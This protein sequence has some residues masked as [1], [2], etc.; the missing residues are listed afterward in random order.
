MKNNIKK[1]R[2]WEMLKQG[3]KSFFTKNIAIKVLSLM[4]AILLWGY[5]LMTQNPPRVKTV[6]D[7]TVSI[8]GEAD[9]TTRKLTLR[10]DRAAL[11]E[12]VSVRVRTELTSYADISADDITASINL[13]R[14]TSTGKHTVRIH[15]KS[16][17]GDVVSV[18]P[19][20]IEVEIDT[21]TTRNI[22]IEI[23]EEGELPEGYWAGD[24]QLDSATVLL[25]GPGTDLAKI[26]K[27][28][29]TIDLTNRTESLNQS[30]M[31]ALYDKEGNVV[32]SS[33]LFGGMPTVVAKQE[34]LPS[35]LVP[36]DVDGA[37]IGREELPENFEIASY[38]TSLESTLVR[39][40]G[41]ADVIQK[42][43]SLSLEPVDVTGCTESIQ[44]EL[45]INVPEGV[46]IIGAD[47]VN[48]Q[49]T[50]REKTAV[51]EL[52]ELP[53]EIVGLARKQTATLSQELA[54]VTFS[55]RVSLLAGITRGDVKVY[56]DVTGLAAG[57]H[58]VK[59]ALQID[60]EDVPSDLQYEFTT[61]ETIQV[62]IE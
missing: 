28:V 34:I 7:V 29:G 8:E 61:D 2:F 1:S 53:I 36:I 31:L 37:I 26:V 58:D 59:L 27:A 52:T 46:R 14:I 13:S 40:V 48:L 38:G 12:D 24:V 22:P 11:L 55:G 57:T 56:A 45:A 35:K 32:E 15:A 43:E 9:L 16:S 5:V 49:V 6:T 4:F 17:S 25:E 20:E 62:T 10:G 60:G 50:I 47:S 3:L 23:H 44:Q 19:S 51:L 21:L 30:I 42:I 39:I 54:N 18:S 41:D 33:I